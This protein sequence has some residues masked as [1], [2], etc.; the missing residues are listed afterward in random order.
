M[1]KIP[2]H[3]AEKLLL[4]QQ[5]A[6][7]SASSAKHAV[8]DEFVDENIIQRTGRVQK[9][10]S[11]LNNDRLK[12]YLQN[13]F[14]INDLD[15]YI[16]TLKQSDF[17]RTDL[18]EVSSNSKLKKVRTFKGFLVNSY[19]PIQAVINGNSFLINPEIGTFTFVS[20]FESFE[21]PSN[22]TI[23]GIENSENFRYIE[24]QK[25]LFENIKPL[26]VCRYPQNQHK[27]LINWLK[28]I[29]N[30]YLHFGDLDFA[31]IGIYLN[32]FKKYLGNRATFF[33]P[34]NANKLLERYGNRGL[35]DNQKNNFSIEEIEE[36]KLKKLITM[37]HEYKRGLEQEVFIKSE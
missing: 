18:T 30:P 5:G 28:S 26:F 37:I 3:I 11:V 1:T 7:I 31:G 6:I 9:S 19:S 10:L 4:L 8:I 27:D 29:Q 16:E 22:I 23:V 2:L 12:V 24:K 35:Y 33:I 21:I 25:Y 14:G 34:D 36:I 15:K 13:K 20:D 32:E 17:K